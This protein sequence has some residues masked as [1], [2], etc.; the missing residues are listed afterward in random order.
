MELNAKMWPRRLGIIGLG[1]ALGGCGVSAAAT[2][3][4]PASIGLQVRVTAAR[5]QIRRPR[6]ISSPGVTDVTLGSAMG[7]MLNATHNA[8]VWQQGSWRFQVVGPFVTAQPQEAELLEGVFQNTPL[9]GTGVVSLEET[10]HLWHAAISW[11]RSSRVWEARFVIPG[12][13]PAMIRAFV[14]HM[15]G[16]PVRSGTLACRVT[17]RAVDGETALRDVMRC[18]TAGRS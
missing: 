16:R 4:A 11:Q 9:R 1:L 18:A 12:T 13:N 7:Y 6:W 3:S 8:V 17:L 14:I 5:D 15:A 10:H 2:A